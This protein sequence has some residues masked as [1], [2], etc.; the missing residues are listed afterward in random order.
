MTTLIPGSKVLGTVTHVEFESALCIGYCQLCEEN[1]VDELAEAIE[2]N[3]QKSSSSSNNWSNDD[4][5]LALFNEDGNW[6]RGK[7]VRKGANEVS[8][9]F[10]DY[11]NT[12]IVSFENVRKLPSLLKHIEP[13]TTKCVLVDETP[14]TGEWTAE[15]IDAV[16]EKLL[17]QEFMFE[18]LKKSSQGYSVRMHDPSSNKS[19][20]NVLTMQRV[21]VNT[22]HLCYISYV[23]SANKFWVQLLE[24]ENELNDMMSQISDHCTSVAVPLPNPRVGEYCLAFYSEDEAPYRSQILTSTSGK[25]LVQFVDYGNSESKPQEELI[26]LP[27]QFTSFPIQGIRCCYKTTK[28]NPSKLEDK[29]H[30][31][32]ASDGGI[33]IKFLKKDND[34]YTVEISEVEQMEGSASS[35]NTKSEFQ[36]N[37]PISSLPS[38]QTCDVC[39]SYVDHPGQFFVQSLS[40]SDTV[41]ELM[42][43]ADEE[44][45]T[46]KPLLSPSPKQSCLAKMSDDG[47]YRGFV[48]STGPSISVTSVDFG[49]TESVESQNLREISEKLGS[50]PAQCMQCTVDLTK[51]SPEHW[52]KEEIDLL[53]GFENTVPL[54]TM[55]TSTR[56]NVYQLDLY[57][58]RDKDIDRYLNEELLGVKKQGKTASAYKESARHPLIIRRIQIPQPD[59][60]VG[61]AEMVCVTAVHSSKQF[62]GQLTKVPIEKFASLQETLMKVYEMGQDVLVD[63]EVGTFCCAKYTDGSWYRALITSVTQ[64]SAEVMFIDFGDSCTIPLSSLYQ[65]HPSIADTP[66][67]CI[68]CQFQKQPGNLSHTDLQGLMMDKVVEVKL[69]SKTG[70][71]ICLI[72]YM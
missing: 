48:N 7:V 13:L 72:N 42:D 24:T 30:D 59:V 43:L 27:V 31:L 1:V 62:F 46:S 47:I 54:V 71:E 39:I 65:I 28:I 2:N 58:T 64:S 5:V 26:T 61:N 4:I 36:H 55:A 35:S 49:F 21:G 18:I 40:S 33:N 41:N 52:S 67:L 8:V 50:I 37:Y 25:C 15:Q 63:G 53:K 16:K 23:E 34:E 10:I 9:F 66:Q 17:Y 20:P 56:S 32:S 60:I 68:M 3:V 29:L 14:V 11:G 19:C 51:M 12:E 44:F 69:L 57:D 38:N 70:N 6:Y 22:R 45:I